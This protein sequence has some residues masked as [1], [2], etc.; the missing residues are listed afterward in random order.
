[1]R[2]FTKEF[3]CLCA[4]K[5]PSKL[6]LSIWQIKES[7][8]QNWN[9]RLREGG[10]F[11]ISQASRPN[12]VSYAN[13]GASMV[14]KLTKNTH[15]TF[16]NPQFQS[17]SNTGEL[18]LTTAHVSTPICLNLIFNFFSG[19][20]QT[21]TPF[22]PRQTAHWSTCRLIQVS[23]GVYRVLYTFFWPAEFPGYHQ[24]QQESQ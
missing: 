19:K 18:W 10:A 13:Y 17:S 14:W 16:I 21:R 11:I 23:L 22:N 7:R 1:M 6:L 12:H 15:F 3:S 20:C 5:S 9:R 2:L 4:V 8:D 24:C